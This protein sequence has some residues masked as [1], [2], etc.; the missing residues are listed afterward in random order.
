MNINKQLD[1][2]VLTNR[3]IEITIRVALVF[4]IVALCFQIIMPFMIPVIWGIIIAV[5]V[6]PLFKKLSV[7][8]GER[9]QL[10]AVIFTLF[11]LGLLIG[12]SLLVSGSLIDTSTHLAEDFKQGGVSIPSPNSS[13]KEWPLIGEKVYDFWS[14]AS[15]NVGATLKQYFPEIKR[16]G[17]VVFSAIAGIGGAILQFVFSIIIA[18]VFLANTQGAYSTTVKVISRLTA[19]EQGLQFT[20]LATATIRSVALGV[21]GVAVIQATL[22]GVAMAIMDVPGW[23]LWTL[24]ILVLAVAQLPPLLMLLPVIFYVFSVSTTVPAVIFTIWS[25]L[26]SL[27]DGLLKP[28]LLGRGMDTPTLVILLGAIGG[29]IFFG[30]LGLFIGAIILALGYELFMAWLD[31]EIAE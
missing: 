28:L 15:N 31:R 5:A 26:V 1:D 11:A 8:L 23:G 4:V 3:V 27:S 7:Q 18:G 20:N 6:F 30:I 25:I 19:K 13:V 9:H 17:E 10:A 24:I 12:P 22:G 2:N 29:M 16:L 14:E 21:V